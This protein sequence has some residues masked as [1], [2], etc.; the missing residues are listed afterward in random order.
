M[1]PPSNA[2]NAAFMASLSNY[3]PEHTNCA[4][5]DLDSNYASISHPVNAYSGSGSPY[6]RPQEV[7]EYRWVCCA[8]KGDNSCD[9]NASCSYCNNH[10]RTSCCYVYAYKR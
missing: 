5:H 9:L 4:H 6:S 3:S 7:Y 10:W 8:C 2:P 1:C